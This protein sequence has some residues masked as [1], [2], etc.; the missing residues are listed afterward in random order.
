MRFFCR[1]LYQALPLRAKAFHVF[2]CARPFGSVAHLPMK[3]LH[4]LDTRCCDC[5]K[6]F[7]DAFPAYIGVDEVEP[8]FR[9]ENAV[10]MQEGQPILLGKGTLQS[11][12]IR[13][14]RII[15]LCGQVLCHAWVWEEQAHRGC[16]GKYKQ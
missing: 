2:I 4:P 7:G 8:C 15:R 5:F 11:G 1:M 16:Q 13:H 3:E 12:S 10:G 14:R 9:I 6:V